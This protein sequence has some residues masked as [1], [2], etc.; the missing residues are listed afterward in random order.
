MISQ[1]GK[2]SVKT[3]CVTFDQPLWLKAFD[4]IHAENLPIAY[5]LG[6]FHNLISFLGSV[7][8]IM[9]G[10]GLEDLLS[11]V[12][13]ENSVMH[14]LSG[15]AVSTEIQGHLIVESSLMPLLLEMVKE[16]ANIDLEE[17]DEFY[18]TAVDGNLD[19]ESCIN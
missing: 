19:E 17:L 12:Y 14:M 11:V 3:L 15:K 4:I 18:D 16:K 8:A 13:V 6:G 1:A 5:R 7:V 10:S 9:K 2:L